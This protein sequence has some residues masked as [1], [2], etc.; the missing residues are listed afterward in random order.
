VGAARHQ[1][2]TI[3]LY[4]S[5]I[6]VDL[7]LSALAASLTE[8]YAAVDPARRPA[9]PSQLSGRIDFSLTRTGDRDAAM[10]IAIP[11]AIS[12]TGADYALSIGAK[13]PALSMHFDGNAQVVTISSDFGAIDGTAPLDWLGAMLAIG[14]SSKA[15]TSSGNSG[16]GSGDPPP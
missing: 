15:P 8:L 11:S 4:P 13:S 2:A 1:P 10:A 14:C 9:I 7:D 5:Q 3:K 6:S 12:I 16:S